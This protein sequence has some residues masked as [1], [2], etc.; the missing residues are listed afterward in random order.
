[1]YIKK[2]YVLETKYVQ[3]SKFTQY[4]KCERIIYM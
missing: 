1:M 4:T 3:I 2:Y